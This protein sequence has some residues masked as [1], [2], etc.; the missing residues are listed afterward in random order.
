MLVNRYH[1]YIL[2]KGMERKKSCLC[3]YR[4]RYKAGERSRLHVSS[5]KLQ[6]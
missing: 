1:S 3:K 4:L 5:M 2:D 6:I